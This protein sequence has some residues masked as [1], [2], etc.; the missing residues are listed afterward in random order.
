MLTVPECGSSKRGD[1]VRI[2]DRVPP[3]FATA[4]QVGAMKHSRRTVLAGLAGGAATTGFLR[5]VQAQAP[6]PREVLVTPRIYFVRSDGSDDNH[7][8]FNT[9]NA[10][11]RTVAMALATAVKLD[12]AG[13]RVTISIGAPTYPVTWTETIEIVHD[14]TGKLSIVGATGDAADVILAPSGRECILGSFYNIVSLSWLTLRPSPGRH[15]LVAVHGA[16]LFGSDVV[17]EGQPQPGESA[18]VYATRDGYVELSG[19]MVVRGR[20]GYWLNASHNGQIRLNAATVDFLEDASFKT[21]AYALAKSEIVITDGSTMSGIA[22]G[23]R[24]LADGGWIQWMGGNEASFPGSIPG[25]VRNGGV[26][27]TH[28]DD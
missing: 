28:S 5:R 20:S 18:H 17:F 3:R 9:A 13:F 2:H 23:R 16:R 4:C 24:Y 15:A 12:Q 27:K 10:A 1:V 21:V 25:T 7:G 22:Q 26:Y 6:T 19:A 11:F 14:L 8:L